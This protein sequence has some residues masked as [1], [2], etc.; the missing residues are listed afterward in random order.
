MDKETEVQN[1][2]G[3]FLWELAKEQGAE[4]DSTRSHAFIA[5]IFKNLS[6]KIYQNEMYQTKGVLKRDFSLSHKVVV[7]INISRGA[8]VLNPRNSDSARWACAQESAC[9]LS[10]LKRF[11]SRFLEPY[12]DRVGY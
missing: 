4:M 11:S 5:Y 8:L 9:L 6:V 10:F 3:T 7:T 12:L 1:V 2:N